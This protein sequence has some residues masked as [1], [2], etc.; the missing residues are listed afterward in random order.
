MAYVL[1]YDKSRVILFTSAVFWVKIDSK[2]TWKIEEK[3]VIHH[4]N[5]FLLFILGILL[6]MEKTLSASKYSNPIGSYIFLSHGETDR[7]FAT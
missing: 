7:L 1:A 4:I 3:K 2:L 6:K 5:T